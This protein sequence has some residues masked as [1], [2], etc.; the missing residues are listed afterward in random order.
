MKRTAYC[1]LAL[2]LILSL[3]GCG[4]G[5]PLQEV[6]PSNAAVSAAL[7]AP[8]ATATP[9]VTV[10]PKAT[11]TP[12]AAVTPTATE[13]PETTPTATPRVFDA[14]AVAM[15]STP[16]STCFSEVGYDAEWEVLVVRFRDSGSVYTYSCFPVSEWDEFIAA[17]SLGSWYNTYIKGQYDCER[18][19]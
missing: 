8:A 11:L 2:L 17:D 6:S 7:S 3:A 10:A 14:D 16:D 4:K 1:L 5:G 19:S 18:I 15:Q 13:T 9:D 12:T